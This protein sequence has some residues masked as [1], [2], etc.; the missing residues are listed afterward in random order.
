[1]SAQMP[2][3]TFLQV[4][5]AR[6]SSVGGPAAE[7]A[8]ASLLRHA[9]ALRFRRDDGR[10]G[11]WESRAAPSAGGMSALRILVLPIEDDT[12]AGLYDHNDHG[13]LG[14][15]VLDAAR[16]L[17][18]D[19]ARRLADASA[20]TTLQIVADTA[21]YDACYDAPE[22]LLWRDAG[23][24][25]ATLA[26]IATAL[27]LRSTILGRIGDDIAAAAQMGDAWRGAGAIHVSA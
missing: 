23:A 9:T 3:G 15:D 21:S 12:P 27:T 11:S 2:A 20:G 16:T 19:G 13:L 4:L 24:L 14:G 10:F 5:E 8:V 22:T 26:L 1:M 6:R 18:A 17:S 25:C 7:E